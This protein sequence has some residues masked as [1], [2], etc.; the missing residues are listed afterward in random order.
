MATITKF[1]DL[2]IWQLARILCK[3]VYELT[4]SFKKE[5]RLTEQMKSSSR[6]ILENITEGFDRDS[7]LEFINFLS[8]AKSS[9]GELKS[10]LYYCLD[11][12]LIQEPVFNELYKEIDIISSKIGGFIKYLNQ[13]LIKGNKFKNRS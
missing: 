9:C 12:K 10:Q 8:I 6:S 11:C 3:K 5:F 1:E 7:R 2:E 4:M 13:S